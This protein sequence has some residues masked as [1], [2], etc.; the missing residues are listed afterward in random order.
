[1]KIERRVCSELRIGA[2]DSQGDEGAMVLTGYAAK[3]N[4]Q[5]EDLG[6]FRETVMP[7]AFARSIRDGQ[8]VKF[9][10]NHNPDYVMGRT[11]NGTLKLEEDGTGL[12]FRVVLPSTQAARDLYANVKR[13]D[14]DQCSF[15]FQAKSQS[16]ED[17]RDGN[18]DLYANRKL[19]DV[20]LMDC[21]AVTYPAYQDTEVK[22]RNK[23]Q[24]TAEMRS[25][26]C[27]DEIATKIAEKRGSENQPPALESMDLPVPADPKLKEKWFNAFNDAYQ[28]IMKKGG[29][30]MEIKQAIGHAI[31]KANEAVA[32]QTEVTPEVKDQGKQPTKLPYKVVDTD[33]DNDA[34]QWERYLLHHG[35]M[36]RNEDGTWKFSV[37]IDERVYNSPSDVPDY[38][39]AD[40]KAQW[41]E[42]W[43]SVYKKSKKDGMADDK[44][45]SK[46][47]AQA[48]SVTGASPK[49]SK[50]DDQSHAEDVSD[51]DSDNYDPDDPDYDPKLDSSSDQYNSA[52]SQETED[53]DG[54]FRTVG[55]VK[56]RATDF[57][58]APDPQDPKTWKLP[59]HDK[60]HVARALTLR[61]SETKGIPADKKE[62]TFR[63]LIELCKKFGVPVTEQDS[64]RCGFDHKITLAVLGGEEDDLALLKMKQRQLEVT[65]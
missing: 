56:L 19:M 52:R 50:R 25:I 12:R 37:A 51:P 3:F 17:G 10:M 26:G 48:N 5:S 30:G 42:V 9:L 63:T 57:L 7:G 32:L 65:L 61:F 45:E 22:A 4:T 39:P 8:D 41:K 44:A 31:A 23:E 14:I 34:D 16:W 24:F 55:G 33:G 59:I 20:D 64:M 18:G 53:Q 58:W 40:K 38:V 15:A 36:F 27:P 60:D 2:P 21:S 54:K 46:A 11:K 49:G 47:F 29:R 28:E 1:M 6:G 43:N 62:T 35:M 13:G